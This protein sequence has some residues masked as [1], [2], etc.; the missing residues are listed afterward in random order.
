[1]FKPA[2][3]SVIK[4]FKIPSNT[5][6]KTPLVAVF[7]DLDI[8]V[9]EEDE[10]KARG[11]IILWYNTLLCM[12][13]PISVGNYIVKISKSRGDKIIIKINSRNQTIC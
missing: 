5:T 4:D 9:E 2:I 1:M 12:P 13:L 3:F 6:L 11:K 7:D 10:L 8:E